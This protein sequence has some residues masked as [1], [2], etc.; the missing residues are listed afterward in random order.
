M[1]HSFAGEAGPPP[2][3]DEILRELS[4]QRRITG[5]VRSPRKRRGPNRGS[6][7]RCADCA[8]VGPSSTIAR[9][10][11]VTRRSSAS[12]DQLPGLLFDSGQDFRERVSTI[13]MPADMHERV[14]CQ[15]NRIGED[16]QRVLQYRKRL[17]LM[18]QSCADRGRSKGRSRVAMSGPGSRLAGERRERRI[19]A[20]VIL[21]STYTQKGQADRR[22]PWADW[23]PGE[24]AR[25]V[26]QFHGSAG[27]AWRTPSSKDRAEQPGEP[28][29]KA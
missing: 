24:V 20:C 2:V 21:F 1:S 16:S 28:S 3:T 23:R 13:K 18:I 10:S 19:A 27:V 4:P 9:S 5:S 26:G 11:S 8:K 22:G 14:E 17:P 7:E 12:R 15:Q 6:R 29:K 25:Q